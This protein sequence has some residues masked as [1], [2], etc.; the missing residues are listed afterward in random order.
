MCTGAPR[1][2]TTTTHLY[3]ELWPWGERGPHFQSL[4]EKLNKTHFSRPVGL[5]LGHKSKTDQQML[6]PPPHQPWAPLTLCSCL[7]LLWQMKLNIHGKITHGKN[8]DR[9]WGIPVGVSLQGC[10]PD[11]LQVIFHLYVCVLNVFQMSSKVTVRKKKKIKEKTS[12]IFPNAARPTLIPAMLAPNILASDRALAATFPYI[13]AVQ[14]RWFL[15]VCQY[16]EHSIHQNH[17][18]CTR[19][20]NRIPIFWPVFNRIWLHFF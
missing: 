19:A 5:P 11:K 15:S 14:P 13:C 17:L 6:S 10:T 3:V 7:P 12:N 9:I 8:P 2:P 20:S 4:T 16:L 18:T 1:F